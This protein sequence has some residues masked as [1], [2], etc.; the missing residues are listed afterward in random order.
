MPI[1]KVALFFGGVS[2]EHE[3]SIRSSYFIFKTIPRDF[4]SVV[5]VFIDSV[6]KF[7]IPENE[8]PTYPDL[9]DK[10]SSFFEGEFKK[11]N[12]FSAGNFFE[13]FLKAKFDAVFLGLHGGLGENGSIQGFLDVLGIPYTGSGVLASALAMDKYRSNLLFQ[14]IG[15]P[16]AP[17]VEIIKGRD[18]VKKTVLNLPFSFPIF[19]KPTLGG[20]S[21]NTGPAHTPEEAITFIEKVFVSESRVLLQELVKGTEVSIGVI[22]KKEG[23]SFQTIPL[24]PTEIRPKSEFFDYEAKYKK[25]ASE[26]ITPAEISKELTET[27]QNYTVLCHQTLGC[28]GYSRTDFIIRDGI[29]FVLETN[30]LPGMTGTSLIPQQAKYMNIKMEDVFRYLLEM[31]L[32]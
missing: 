27:L 21:V 17:F 6:G 28:R 26:E 25:G 19:V 18:D 9:T 8:T 23:N 4:F 32:V 15:L 12:H 20:S 22:E 31:A 3:I 7:W 29:P 30:T 13:S 1:K 5:P 16:V 11:L 24:V 14:K 2:T 10:S